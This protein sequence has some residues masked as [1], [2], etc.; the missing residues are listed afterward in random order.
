MRPV[1]HVAGQTYHGRKGA[2]RNAFR[3]GVDYV[4]LDAEGPT[5]APWLFGRNR[6]WALA[7][8]DSDHGGAPGQDLTVL[9]CTQVPSVLIHHFDLVVTDAT[10]GLCGQGALVSTGESHGYQRYFG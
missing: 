4:L 3:Y 10:V 1:D 9:I 6:G 5:Q 8:H 7:V 2:I